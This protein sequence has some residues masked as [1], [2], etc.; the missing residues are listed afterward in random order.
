MQSQSPKKR[1]RRV[2]EDI[3][4]LCRE[5]ERMKIILSQQERMVN[6]FTYSRGIHGTAKLMKKKK[7]VVATSENGERVVEDIMEFIAA[8]LLCGAEVLI[9]YDRPHIV[10]CEEVRKML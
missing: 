7:V 6:T 10:T 8:C 2:C 3:G 5:E 1:T 4:L 9:Q